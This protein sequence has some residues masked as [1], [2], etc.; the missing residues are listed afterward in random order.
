MNISKWAL[1]IIFFALAVLIFFT[2]TGLNIKNPVPAVE[3]MLAWLAQ[4]NRTINLQ[5]RI[6]Y[7]SIRTRLNEGFR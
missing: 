1:I 2:L 3:R 7:Q 4:L 6:F 5:M